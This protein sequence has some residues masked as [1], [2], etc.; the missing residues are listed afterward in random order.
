MHIGHLVVANEVRAALEL[1]RM[2]LVVAANP[3]QKA[4]RD[5][6]PAADRLALVEAAIEGV[7][8]LEVSAIELA[9]EGPTYTA[10][11]LAELA[12]PD[13]ELFLVV[14]ADVADQLHTWERPEQVAEL[15]TLV[16]TNRE[17]ERP[18]V[19]LPGFRV[20]AVT[21]PALAVSSSE[22]RCRLAEGRPVDFLVPGPALRL[23]RERGLYARTV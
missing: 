1:D 17:D 6:T 10:D 14:G 15:A 9:R 21:V 8:G 13:R 4:D 23:L 3:W 19:E 11:T 2:L 12:A 7:D 5:I 20:L 16:V 22:I 18:T